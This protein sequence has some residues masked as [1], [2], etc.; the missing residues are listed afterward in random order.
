MH[1]D[2]ECIPIISNNP[3]GSSGKEEYVVCVIFIQEEMIVEFCRKVSTEPAHQNL[4]PFGLEIY[5][6]DIFHQILNH[7]FPH[8]TPLKFSVNQQLLLLRQQSHLPM[9]CVIE[10]AI[11][12]FIFAGA[13]VNSGRFGGQHFL[14]LGELGC[15]ALLSGEGLILKLTEAGQTYPTAFFGFDE[16]QVGSDR[17]NLWIFY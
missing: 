5:R 16:V 12:E 10:V 14:D 9:Q 4:D 17:S 11:E 3:C 6:T 15:D 13:A 8:S 2:K 7:P 1:D